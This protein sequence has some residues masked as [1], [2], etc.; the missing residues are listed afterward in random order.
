MKLHVLLIFIFFVSVYDSK[1]QVLVDENFELA[2]NQYRS[3]LALTQDRSCFPRTVKHDSLWCVPAEDWTS[4]F[5]PGVLWYLYEKTHK[6]S[7]KKEAMKW[8]ERLQEI[9]YFTG[10]HDIGFMMYCSYGNGF[11][12]TATPRYIPILVQS[13]KSLC[14]RYSYNV[15]CIQSWNSRMSN[16]G[17]NRWDYPVII[18]NM[19]N[20]ELLFWA[21]LATKD[22]TYWNIAVSH[23]EKTMKNHIRPDFSCYHVVNYDPN[24][25]EVLHRQTAQ[26]FADNSTWARGQAWGIYSF[27]MVYRYTKD[28]RFL[29]TAVNMADFFLNHTNLPNDRIPYW[30]LSIGDR[31]NMFNLKCDTNTKCVVYRDVSASCIVASALLELYN[32]VPDLKKKK[33]YFDSSLKI[34]ENLSVDKYRAKKGENHGFILKH[35]VGNYPG[36]NEI[37]VPLIYA[38]Y[39]FLEALIRYSK[40]NENSDLENLS[41]DIR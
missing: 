15:G 32:Y 30:D 19:M 12:L 7:W 17:R 36:K 40:I 10:L 41:V 21:T 33:F 39:Y 16:D 29:R 1:C 13:A 3:M 11:R 34:L 35:S 8:T 25:G 5:W 6:S 18:D 9:Q 27:T 4:G 26:G 23:A 20:L 31:G 28:L 2:E 38:D 24:T 22:S 14:K 37:D